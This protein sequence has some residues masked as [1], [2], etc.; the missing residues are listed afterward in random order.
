MQI[1][2]V[3]TRE[4]E[5]IEPNQSVKEAAV[6]MKETDVGPLPICEDGRVVGILTDRDIVVRSTAQGTHPNEMKVRN[7]MSSNII[8]VRDDEDLST[9]EQ[10]MEQNQI[11]RL[12]VVDRHQKLA[13]IIGIAD[14]ANRAGDLDR[15]AKVVKEVAQAKGGP[16]RTVGTRVTETVGGRNVRRQ[17]PKIIEHRAA[18]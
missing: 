1:K 7:V 12:P 5:C 15:T 8:C 10:L 18:R 14:I 9:A 16:R 11:R 6:R 17:T 3:M 4:V 13:G 2:D